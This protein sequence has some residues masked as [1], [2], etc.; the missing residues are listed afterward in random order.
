E[1]QRLEDQRLDDTV[2]PRH[3]DV[4]LDI[5]LDASRFAGRV[6]IDAE[7]TRATDVVRLHAIDLDVTDVVVSTPGGDVANAHELHRGTEQLHLRCERPLEP[8]AAT[9]EIGFSGSL[10]DRLVG[11]YRST[12]TVDDADGTPHEH[13]LAVTQ[14][15]ST[16]ARRA[17]PCF[18]EPAFKATF[19]LTVGAPDDAL[20]LANTLAIER[21]ALPDGTARTRFATTVPMSTYLVALVVGPLEASET[22]VVDGRNGPIPLRV[23]HRPGVGHL[24]GFALDVA[25]A[26]LHFFERYYDCPYPGDKVD[27]VAVP[28]FAFGAME[29]LG[30]ITFREVLLLID[31]DDSTQAELQRVADVINHELAHMWF[32]D[33]VTMR[34][35]N[36]LWLNEAF[37]T[38]MEVT[39]SDAF[40]PDWDCWT[41]FGLLRS[42]AFDTDSLQATRPIEYPV[43]TAADAEGMFDVLTYEKGASIVRMLE[44]YLQ[45]ERFR[46]GIA[47]YLRRH[48][49]SNTDTG[50]LWDAIE[51]TAGEPV[52]SIMDAWIF[53]GG[54]PEVT[55]EFTDTGVTLLQRR[56]RFDDAGSGSDEMWP[57]PMVVTTSRAGVDRTHRLVLG[58]RAELDLG[59]P[60]DWIQPNT[61][62]DGFFRTRLP[63]DGALALVAAGRP[64]LERFMLLD[65][66][67]AAI[68]AGR[69]EPSDALALI[70]RLSPIETNP[71]VWR[72]IAGILGDVDRLA[73]PDTAS[74]ARATAVAVANERLDAI[75]AEVARNGEPTDERVRSIR[76]ICFALAGS[77][78]ADAEVQATARQLFHDGVG[79][80][81]LRSASTDVVAHTATHDEHA[82]IEQRWRSAANPQDELR[83]LHALADTPDLVDLERTLE[84]AL[85]DVRPQNQPYL[86]RRALTNVHHGPRAWSFVT[87]RWSELTASI[88][89]IGMTRLLEGIRS[90]DD[91]ALAASVE[92][93]ITEH[94]PDD[95][96]P[97][98]DQHL[99]RMWVNVRAAERLR[100]VG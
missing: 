8:G 81:S 18:D 96:S 90:F 69:A 84:L 32:G 1:D 98:V 53:R 4:Q 95:P 94:R 28:D 13:A 61:G 72:R 34:W 23:I 55:V 83:Y 79:D 58:E 9:F 39:A 33:L 26:A 77:V 63:V 42:A 82:A 99:E 92:A 35:W 91:A 49:F 24:S 60:P 70:E 36:G 37:A 88:T 27:L 87:D 7:V 100:R 75:G 45:P 64:P 48:E 85:S 56:F 73:G 43:V 25:E 12:F 44:Q 54:H 76:S 22:R 17:F 47:E 50:D 78:G 41:G 86:L 97:V 71:S 57:I 16:H 14:F 67:W 11:L 20:V 31:A 52:R 2:L 5:D 68:L 30:C 10:G 40:Q 66:L 59:G 29:N 89:T 38:F 6:R 21:T 62:G 74:A 80:A 93:F 3:Y 19:D 51:A 65:D 46:A 15:E